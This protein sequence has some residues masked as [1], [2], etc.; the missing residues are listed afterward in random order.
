MNIIIIISFLVGL[1]NKELT[2]LINSILKHPLIMYTSL[3]EYFH[4]FT[5]IF[6]FLFLFKYIFYLYLIYNLYN[7]LNF[8]IHFDETFIN[9]MVILSFDDFKNL[10]NNVNDPT[11]N[12]SSHTPINYNNLIDNLPKTI[13]GY[14]AYKVGMEVSKNVP[15]IGGKALVTASAGVLAA[16]SI[17][18]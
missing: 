17:T 5:N 4:L 10:A 9:N 1:F 6:S 14:D 15:S 2:S 8:Y 7:F 16:G 13:A 3:K 11:L 18:F 12:N